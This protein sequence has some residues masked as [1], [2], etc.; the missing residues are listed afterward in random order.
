MPMAMR[1]CIGH[2][3]HIKEEVEELQRLAQSKAPF[4][5]GAVEIAR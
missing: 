4:G 5:W 3:S 2:A 1:G